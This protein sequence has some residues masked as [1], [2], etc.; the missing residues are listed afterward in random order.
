MT[1]ITPLVNIF[2]KEAFAAEVERVS[3][4]GS[5]AE[6]IANRMNRTIR[7]KWEEDP[8]YYK[9]FSELLAQLIRSFKER[10]ISE[11]E[12][13]KLVKAK[14]DE[15]RQHEAS[16]LPLS[17]ADKPVA[18]AFYGTL[19]DHLTELTMLTAQEQRVISEE[20]AHHIQATVLPHASIVDWELNMDVQNVMLNEIE[21]ALLDAAREHSFQFPPD[22]HLLDRILDEILRIV[23]A[24]YG[25][26][27][28]S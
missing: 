11:N 14:L 8:A 22:H 21:D 24:Q 12:Y 6:T 27:R 4:D 23:K 5:K 2:D 28:R 13:L 26:K 7:E 18:R 3:G 19:H 25:A 17:V 16:G 9:R 15:L 1:R 20:L 10:R